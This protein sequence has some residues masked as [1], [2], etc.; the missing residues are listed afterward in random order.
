M[1]LNRP[2]QARRKL[3]ISKPLF[4]KWVATGVINKSWP[5]GVDPE[6]MY[7]VSDTEIERLKGIMLKRGWKRGKRLLPKEEKAR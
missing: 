5:G 6:E 4:Y 2:E 1:K 7:W 3:R